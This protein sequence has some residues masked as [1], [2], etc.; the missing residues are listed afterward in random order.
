MQTPCSPVIMLSLMIVAVAPMLASFYVLM[1]ISLTLMSLPDLNG[2]LPDLNG[3][4]PDLN[5]SVPDLTMY[6]LN[7]LNI[8]NQ[9]ESEWINYCIELSRGAHTIFDR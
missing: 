9:S 6:F 8:S 4:L 1:G 7:Y 3:N 5:G 2:N